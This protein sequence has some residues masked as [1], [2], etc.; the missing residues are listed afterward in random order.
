M[1]DR[2][3]RLTAGL[4]HGI[5]ERDEA[6]SLGL[7]ALLAGES[8]FLLGPP[9]TAKSLVARRLKAA[10]S[11]A[12]AF[13]YL[14]GRF[15]TPEEIF[16]PLSIAGLRDRDVFERRTS[17]YLPE[18][19]VAFLDEV[20][21]ASPPIQNTLL[22]ILN[23]KRF[24]NGDHEI[25]VPL[26]L[27]VAASNRAPAGEENAEA[28][29]D[30]FVVRLEVGPLTTDE[31]FRGLVTDT[32]D[33]Y[34]PR[35]AA[36]DAL[37]PDEWEALQMGI[38][39]VEVPDPVVSALGSLRRALAE[40]PNPIPVSDRRWKKASRLLRACAVAHGRAF[41]DGQDLGLLEHVLWDRPEQ[42]PRVAE[43][44][45]RTLEEE[46][47][48]G[49]ASLE[50]LETET[51]ALRGALGALTLRERTITRPAPV[52]QDGEYFTLVGYPGDLSARVWAQDFALLQTDSDLEGE[53]FFFTPYGPFRQSEK[54]GLRATGAP[55][56]VEV[57]GRLF[58]LESRPE[59]VTIYDRIPPDGPK[60]RAWE[61]QAKELIARVERARAAVDAERVRKKAEADLHLFCRAYTE[62]CGRGLERDWADLGDL[63]VTLETLV[64]TRDPD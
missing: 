43:L 24:R 52:L 13:E 12:R 32:S 33:P 55:A 21:R 61:T 58:A 1:R 35:V 37:N 36:A 26:K 7:L 3:L 14:M 9:G 42:K 62:A 25:R 63:L 45:T 34:R 8:L 48:P 5:H 51:E 56:E 20:W 60:L 38:D 6:L 40:D 2:F 47:W 23:E 18:A 57:D 41:V 64:E 39:L 19:D 53:L 22:T 44:L 50:T 4:S 15:S 28:F 17:G 27:L 29:W 11:G 54:H 30:R 59:E 46:G 49:P 10:L 31:G 16:G